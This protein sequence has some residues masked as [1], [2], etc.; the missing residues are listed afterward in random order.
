MPKQKDYCSILTKEGLRYLSNFKLFHILFNLIEY[1]LD[2]VLL[3]DN[4]ILIIQEMSLLGPVQVLSTL[5]ELLFQTQ[6][7]F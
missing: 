6:I 1:K 3:F 5:M 7:F 4:Y 2:L